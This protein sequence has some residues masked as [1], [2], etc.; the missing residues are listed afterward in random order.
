VHNY[1]YPS[2]SDAA[3]SAAQMGAGGLEFQVG[4]MVSDHIL[5]GLFGSFEGGSSSAPDRLIKGLEVRPGSVLQF[6]TGGQVGVSIPVGSWLLRG[7][8]MVGLRSTGLSVESQ[9]GDCIQRS[10]AWNQD[11]LLEPRVGIEKWLSP[12]LSAGVM[13]GSDVL[14]D[15]DLSVTLGITG[16][17]S[18]FDS[19]SVVALP[20]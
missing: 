8:A 19:R 2:Q 7:D 10:V 4:A 15:R 14:R 11:L 17:S 12:W 5:L 9:I 18:A 16:H 3:G 13:V 1:H 6:K 20:D